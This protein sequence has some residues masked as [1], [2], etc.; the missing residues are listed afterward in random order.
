VPRNQLTGCNP[1]FNI[2]D[3][4]TVQ[5]S[6]LSQLSVTNSQSSNPI[7]PVHRHRTQYDP[8]SDLLPPVEGDFADAKSVVERVFS[9]C[10]TQTSPFTPIFKSRPGHLWNRRNWQCNCGHIIQGHQSDQVP[11]CVRFFMPDGQDLPHQGDP[12]EP[13][14][15]HPSTL[16][17]GAAGLPPEDFGQDLEQEGLLSDNQKDVIKGILESQPTIQPLCC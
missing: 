8:I 9:G 11:N 4:H 13:A 1:P 3:T 12:S 10:L 7:N 17:F 15:Q 5:P 2:I 16:L 6:I 14:V